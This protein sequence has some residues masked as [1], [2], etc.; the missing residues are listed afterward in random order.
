MTMGQRLADCRRVAGFTQG[1]VAKRLMVTPQAVSKWECDSGTPDISLLLP[2]AKLYGVTTDAL[3][4]ADNTDADFMMTMASLDDRSTGTVIERY[5]KC[6]SM[7]RDHP[8]DM[9]VFARL[10]ELTA[11]VIQKDR[12]ITVEYRNAL[13]VDA[14][15]MVS[16]MRSH[17]LSSEWD[18]R[19]HVGMARVY[20]AIGNISR[21]EEEIAFLPSCRYTKSRLHGMLSMGQG[22]TDTAIADYRTSVT[23]SLMWMLWD[24]ERLAGAYLKTDDRASMDRM[25]S[26]MYSLI[27]VVSGK[28]D[29]PFP[30]ENFWQTALMR[31]AQKAARE[32]QTEE[33]FGYLERYMASI[34]TSLIL[35]TSEESNVQAGIISSLW[36]DKS[37]MESCFRRGYADNCRKRTAGMLG[38][39]AF[40]S[41]RMDERFVSYI[42]ECDTWRE[43]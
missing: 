12:E 14:E 8:F 33:A 2:L 9:L 26:L 32:G 10:L 38:W 23:E 24:M 25:Y 40:D 20:E 5:E 1:E 19:I 13:L 30:L 31:R 41:I 27:E 22:K 34:R 35:Y 39:H 6:R 3:L 18:A 29:C 7:L 42:A 17:R 11:E 16:N 37:T 43:E 28:E 15:Y 21:A 36:L 4:G